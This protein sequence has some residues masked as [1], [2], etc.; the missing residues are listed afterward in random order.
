MRLAFELT[1]RRKCLGSVCGSS[2][3]PTA[4]RGSRDESGQRGASRPN[5]NG[6]FAVSDRSSEWVLKVVSTSWLVALGCQVAA[7]SDT[8][9]GCSDL[10]PPA[11][12]HSQAGSPPT[13]GASTATSAVET[14]WEPSANVT[15]DTPVGV[16]SRVTPSGAPPGATSHGDPSRETTAVEGPDSQG[17][18]SGTAV[19]SGTTTS[20]ATSDVLATTGDDSVVTGGTNAQVNETVFPPGVTKPKILII[21]DSIS[22]GPGCY[23]KFLDQKLKDSGITNYEF[24][25]EYTDD[26]G[27]GV[28]HGAVSCTTTADYL[29][30]S[31]NLNQAG[32][33]TGERLGM[34]PMIEKFR[35]DLILLQLGVND[36]WGG[37]QNIDAILDNYERLIEQARAY[38]PNVV[39][40]V[41]QIHKIKTVGGCAEPKTPDPT[42]QALVD[43]IPAWVQ[44]VTNTTSPVLVADLW[45]NSLV[46][47]SDDCV[48]PNEAGA[49]RMAENWYDALEPILR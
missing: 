16:S 12:S 36:V 18:G 45:T 22:A 10:Q 4:T 29:Q 25:G 46:T 41:A 40:A 30:A 2:G 9:G 24:V 20:V 1:C 7:C 31:F 32:C 23:K 5:S 49:E 28:L 34:G 14:T 27:G 47:E 48:H 17:P 33:P 15:A 13:S 8:C 3:E 44:E 11:S 38:N 35:P 19:A 42:A 39:V 37:G 26:C 21:G 6:M 43:A